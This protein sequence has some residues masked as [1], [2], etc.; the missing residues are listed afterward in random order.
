MT[1][2]L[3]PLPTVYTGNYPMAPLK[4]SSSP[5]G[6][7]QILKVFGEAGNCLLIQSVGSFNF[8]LLRPSGGTPI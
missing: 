6:W 8:T 2:L 7:L 5:V 4:G 3:G 1:Q